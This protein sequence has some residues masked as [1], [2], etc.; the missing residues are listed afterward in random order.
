ML[1]SLFSCNLSYCG[2]IIVIQNCSY[3]QLQVQVRGKMVHVILYLLCMGHC[4][5]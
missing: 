5:L 2:N 1:R 4:G 3:W